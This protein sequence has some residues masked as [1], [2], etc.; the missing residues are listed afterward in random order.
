[1]RR[2]GCL[3]RVWHQILRRS[4]FGRVGKTVKVVKCWGSVEGGGSWEAIA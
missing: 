4:S 3:R 2:R 1:M